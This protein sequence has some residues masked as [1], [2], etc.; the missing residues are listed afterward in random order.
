MSGDTTPGVHIPGTRW[1]MSGQL[2]APT[3]LLP[4]PLFVGDYMDHRTSIDAVEKRKSHRA[5]IESQ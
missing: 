5:G 3:D 2:H 4:V 1:E